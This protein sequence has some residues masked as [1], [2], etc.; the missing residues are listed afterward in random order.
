MNLEKKSSRLSEKAMKTALCKFFAKHDVMLFPSQSED[1]VSWHACSRLNAWNI[2]DVF[3]WSQ[4]QN[5]WESCI[6]CN[7][8]K[9]W[10]ALAKALAE[11][12]GC[13][14]IS[15]EPPSIEF[16][17]TPGTIEEIAVEGDLA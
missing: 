14:L 5:Q 8:G 4:R 13:L 11:S 1:E 15:K 2:R 6:K 3:V 16:F 9:K 12:K 17:K 10:L 7:D